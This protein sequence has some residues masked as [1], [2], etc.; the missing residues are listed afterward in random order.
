MNTTAHDAFAAGSPTHPT[1]DL[2]RNDPRVQKA[3]VDGLVRMLEQQA[4]QE[5][6]TESG[7]VG[8]GGA[9]C[10]EN[11]SPPVRAPRPFSRKERVA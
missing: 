8:P 9:R 1:L 10:Q 7:H 2:W 6:A 3:L 11:P 4:D 5:A